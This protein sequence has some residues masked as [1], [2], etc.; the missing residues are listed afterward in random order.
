MD[1]ATPL[2]KEPG[3]LETAE[4]NGEV[5]HADGGFAENAELK[6]GLKNR[7]IQMIAL[8]GTIGT[9]LFLSTGNAL[10]RGGPLG[11]LLAYTIVGVLVAFVVISIAEL[12]ALVPLSGGIL[13][14]AHYFCD[15]ALA[16]AQGWNTVYATAILQPA[17]MVAAA[18]IIQFWITIS[19][20]VWI[21]VLG[22]LLI[23]SNFFF[24]RIYGELEF[25]FA[26]L[27]ILLVVGSI[28]MVSRD[29]WTNSA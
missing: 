22:G 16:F 8:A 12:N 14:P 9:G 7:H 5:A 10:A 29:S 25:I 13:R 17:E 27:K 26:V 15:P 6:R 4:D 23:L 1:N 2:E 11:A 28:I 19:P 24:V 18:V 20:A 3:V 21:S